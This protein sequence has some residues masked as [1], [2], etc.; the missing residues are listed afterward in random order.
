MSRY[1]CKVFL[2]TFPNMVY[3][4]CIMSGKSIRHFLTN[5]VCGFVYNK[6]SR[7]KLRVLL[8]S[9]LLTYVR[10]IRRDTGLRA[11]RM[12][13][14]IGYKARSLIIGVNNKWIYKFPLRRDNYRELA[15]RE[16][17]IVRVLA[18]YANAAV[19]DVKIINHRGMLVRK[20]PF[21]KGVGLRHAPRE[22]IMANM[23]K[24][25]A[26]VARFLYD[27]A[28]LDPDEIRDL[29][30][31]PDATPGYMYGWNQGDIC[32]NFMIDLETMNVCAYIDWED[33][34]FWDFSSMFKYNKNGVIRE[35]MN[36]VHVEY[37]KLWNAAH[38]QP[39]R[40]KA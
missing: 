10:F 12:R 7:K 5:V 11:P 15:M 29:K 32:D 3:I 21:V 38:K 30:P 31:A 40:R 19:P 33:A 4:F 28:C 20:Y 16:E 25:A 13:A 34:R 6:D 39:C 2:A 22:L 1:L 8:N 37:D 14:F 35:F 23:D 9:P 17:R 24:L 27:I 26:Q 18:P 36:A